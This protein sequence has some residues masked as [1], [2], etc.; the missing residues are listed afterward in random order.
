MYIA[1]FKHFLD[2]NGNIPESNHKAA[3][4]LAGFHALVVDAATS[5]G[6]TDLPI[7]TDLRCY[8]KGCEGK[9]MIEGVLSDNRIEWHCDKCEK[10]GGIISDWQGT[11]W[12]NTK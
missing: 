1:N 10:M 12:D 4:A 9:I 7:L 5:N 11:K 3:I 2:E 8:A 6:L